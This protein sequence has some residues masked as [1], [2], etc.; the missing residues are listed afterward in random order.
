MRIPK[1]TMLNSEL[2][3]FLALTPS[4]H[5]PHGQFCN[6]LKENWEMEQ[7]QAY[8]YMEIA[9]LKT[10]LVMN[11]TLITDALKL[12]KQVDEPGGEP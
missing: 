2:F 12:A 4:S 3:R 7:R 9:M 11:L 5:L 1:P 8:T 10:S 6:W